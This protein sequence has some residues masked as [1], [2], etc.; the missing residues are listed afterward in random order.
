MHLSFRLGSLACVSDIEYFGYWTSKAALNMV[1]AGLALELRS[2][3]VS[4]VVATE[5]QTCHMGTIQPSDSVH[6]LT[7][8]IKGVAME[9]NGKF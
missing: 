1:N 7:T 3:K 8:A 2:H 4:R 5:L 6:G 9:Q